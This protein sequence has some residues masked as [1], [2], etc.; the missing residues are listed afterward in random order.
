ME[1]SLQGQVAIV[2]GVSRSQG[3]GAS[4]CRKLALLGSHLFLTGWPDYDQSESSVSEVDRLVNALQD[5][6]SEV[7]WMPLDLGL[8]DSPAT[9]IE[10]VSSRL[11]KAHVLI[12]TGS[13]SRLLDCKFLLRASLLA[14]LFL[15]S[16]IFH[17]DGL[18][19][20]SILQ[21][22]QLCPAYATGPL[23]LDLRYA[24]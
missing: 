16:L 12:N 19:A 22:I 9:L 13:G 18:F 17:R 21:I 24:R 7:E 10:A 8:S 2:T 4:I 23:N 14:D 11:G 3:I 20:F 15:R 1:K 6:G 5:M